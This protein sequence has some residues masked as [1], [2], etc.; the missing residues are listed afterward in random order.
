M[1]SKTLYD[2]KAYATSKGMSDANIERLIRE[3]ETDGNGNVLD[4]ERV[5]FGI[6]C[7]MDVISN[8]DWCNTEPITF[9]AKYIAIKEEND[10]L[11]KENKRLKEEIDNEEETIQSWVDEYNA[12]CEYNKRLLAENNRLHNE[13]NLMVKD[14]EE[15]CDNY[16]AMLKEKVDINDLHFIFSEYLDGKYEPSSIAI[17]LFQI[18]YKIKEYIDKQKNEC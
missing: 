17:L 8:H 16:I 4:Y 14:H 9:K 7:E 10:C 15:E 11:R 18:M 3:V 13:M 6:D 1:N 5:C 12:R 2:V